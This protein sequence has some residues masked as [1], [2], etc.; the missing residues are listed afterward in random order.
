[1]FMA[2]GNNAREVL[3]WERF[4][5]STRELS[6]M[7]ADDGYHPDV[8]LTIARGG[9]LAAAALAYALSVKNISLVNVEYYTGVDERLDFPVILPSPLDMVDLAGLKV[10]VVDDVA[11]TGHTL[12]AVHQHAT[13]KVREVRSAVIYEKSH[14]TIKCEYV[15]QRTDAWIDFPWSDKSPFLD[16]GGNRVVEEIEGH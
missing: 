5:E 11:D 4:G 8:I 15:Y 6:R 16:R 9:M 12:A 3:T 2:E 7:I 10:L 14:S 13:T 1:M